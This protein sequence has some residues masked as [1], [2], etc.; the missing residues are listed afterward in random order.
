MPFGDVHSHVHYAAYASST[1]KADESHSA[2]LHV[3]VGR[4]QNEP[5]EIHAEAV[6][7]GMRFVMDP[8][9]VIVDYARRRTQIPDE[10]LA[11][12]VVEV[13]TSSWSSWGSGT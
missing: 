12:V 3:V 5:P 4:I 13:Q 2:G 6:V 9:E 11:R 8:Q 10:W 7:D 1:D